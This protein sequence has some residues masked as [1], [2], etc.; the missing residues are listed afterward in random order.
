MEIAGPERRVDEARQVL[1]RFNRGFGVFVGTEKWN[2][3]QEAGLL[4]SLDLLHQFHRAAGGRSDFAQRCIHR[5][6]PGQFRIHVVEQRGA[7]ALVLRLQIDDWRAPLLVGIGP[8]LARDAV[9]LRHL[10]LEQRFRAGFHRGG[11][12][13]SLH[14]GETALDRQ[15]CDK[16]RE[17]V[18]GDGPRICRHEGVRR[19]EKVDLLVDAILDA[20]GRVVSRQFEP[21]GD[22]RFLS[23][24][25]RR[26]HQQ[27]DNSRHDQHGEGNVLPHRPPLQEAIHRPGRGAVQ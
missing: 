12:A 19:A 14:A 18:M 23:S 26:R 6:A 27:A 11:K 21:C 24:E 5:L 2:V 4:L 22:R 9:I 15:P 1:S 16:G 8:H 17:F 20:V 10:L 3:D 25:D 13:D 7:V